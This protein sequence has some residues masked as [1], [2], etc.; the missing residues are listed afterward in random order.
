MFFSNFSIK[1]DSRPC[2]FLRA[3]HLRS[4]F[5]ILQLNKPHFYST[6]NPSFLIVLF[7]IFFL[8]KKWPPVPN[9]KILFKRILILLFLHASFHRTNNN[10]RPETA[11]FSLPIL[12]KKMTKGFVLCVLLCVCGWTPPSSSR[13]LS[14]GVHH[15]VSVPLG[16]L[17]T[18]SP[19]TKK[20][21]KWTKRKSRKHVT[22]SQLTAEKKNNQRSMY[23]LYFF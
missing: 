16:R 10:R 22:L 14:A 6:T 5:K 1:I 9:W 2:F 15:F 18:T 13:L 4:N 23:Y 12:V 17:L 20:I 3:T 21:K 11:A 7:L 8:D 19:P